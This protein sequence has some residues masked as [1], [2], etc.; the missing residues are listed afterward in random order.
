MSK[1]QVYVVG[2]AVRNV[3]L[4]RPV[5]DMDYVVVGATPKEM[6]AAGY[7]QVGADFPVFLKDGDE[8]AL[9]RTERKSGKGYHGFVADAN[10]EITLHQ[11]LERRDLTVNAMAV[12]VDEWAMFVH[13]VNTG[14]PESG[15]VYLEDP[16]GGAEDLKNFVAR[17]C[18]F[19][20]F[21]EDPL[22]LVRAARFT[23]TYN[24]VWSNQMIAAAQYIIKSGELRD[25]SQERYFAEIEKVLKDAPTDDRIREFSLRLIQFKLFDANFYWSHGTRAAIADMATNAFDRSQRTSMGAKLNALCPQY[26]EDAYATRFKFSNALIDQIDFTHSVLNTAAMMAANEDDMPLGSANTLLAGVYESI[27][28]GKT[29]IDMDFVADMAGDYE[30]VK[31][32]SKWLPMVEQVYKEV[33]FATVKPTLEADTPKRMYSTYIHVARLKR[34]SELLNAG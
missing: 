15:Y 10:P 5:K 22:R 13:S 19:E 17:P 21:I 8:Y 27:A 25:L 4:G 16:L 20:T 9:A 33:C 11:D 34:I 6:L 7:V 1:H 18:R 30:D 32:V 28:T 3:L 24:L 31:L 23:A 2:G 26:T 29:G 12:H 14:G